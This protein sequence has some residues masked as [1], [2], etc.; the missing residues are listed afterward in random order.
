MSSSLNKTGKK[1]PGSDRIGGMPP[2]EHEQERIER[3]R[4]AMYSRDLAEKLKER[5]RHELDEDGAGVGEDWT[6]PEPKI[7]GVAVTPR[8]MDL[9]RGILKWLLMIAIVFFVAAVGF[10][11]YFFAFGSGSH[12]ASPNNID[13]T[14]TGPPTIAGGEV[15]ELQ[16]VIANRNGVPLEL[17]DLVVTFPQGTRSPADFATD[18]PSTRIPLGTIPPGGKRQGTIPAVFSGAG[19][20]QSTVKVELEYRVGGSN[21]VFVASRDYAVTFRTSPLVVSIDGNTETVSGQPVQFTANVVSNASAPQKD[22]V[23]RVDYPF[24]FT[25]SSATPAPGA[26]NTWYLGDF[27]PGE[28]KSVQINGVVRGEPGD[29]RVFHLAAG[30]RK[31][32]QSSTIDTKLADNT[33]PIRVS[34]SFLGLS[35]AVNSG[36]QT[37]PSDDPFTSVLPMQSA[38]AG[39]GD[40]VA[41]TISYVNNL[42]S[43]ITDAIIV[44]RLSGVPIDGTQ[45]RTSDGFYRSSDGVVLW[46][47]TTT[48]GK[49]GTIPAGGR[50]TV[51]F[52]FKTPEGATVGGNAFV[53]ISVN[54]AGKRLSETDVPQNLQSAA[55]KKIQ[56]ASNLQLYAQGLY[57]TNPFV[58]NREGPMP[59]KAQIETNYA[60]LFTITNTTSRISKAKLTAHLPSYVRWLGM[61]AP[62]AADITVNQNDGTVTWNIGEIM[63]G[64][65]VGGTNPLQAAILIG[66]TPSTSQIGQVPVLLEDIV[67]TGVDSATGAPIICG[68]NRDSCT[69]KD[70]TTNISGDAGFNPGNSTVV[71]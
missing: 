23:L 15:S 10:F 44:A 39:P 20:T 28:V 62:R 27:A 41:V 46:D 11:V 70:I 66:F 49:L 51:S 13:I 52:T 55:V 60:F 48:R 58:E 24:G 56:I 65:G 71:Q 69:A 61:S 54:A 2:S 68:D 9:T 34:Q 30:T 17:A 35:I 38:V 59:P 6:H 37:S 42:S 25:F 57:H 45:V 18:L 40:T 14:I 33:H 53:D 16:V 21:A 32:A 19:A 3:L 43:P 7:A 36:S 5:P 67:L 47:K 1:R 29:T 50:G 31:S 26:A 64:T 63:P 8:V 12:P 22:V 4:R